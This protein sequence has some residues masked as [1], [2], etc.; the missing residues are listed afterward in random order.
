MK[1]TAKALSIIALACMAGCGGDET[2]VEMDI[3][4]PVTV[5]E[6]EPGSI[7]EYVTTTGTVTASKEVMVRS[8]MAG[9]YRKALNP[10]SNR[11]F[12]LG[13]TVKKDGIIVYLDNPEQENSIRIESVEMN[14]EITKN[15]YEKQQSLY[16]KGGVTLR[17]LRNAEKA[18]LD[19]RLNHE[20]ALL[21]LAKMKITAPFDGVITDIPY[22]TE[23]VKAASGSD[24]VQ[25][26]DYG[27]MTMDVSIPGK[28]MGDIAV[29][30]ETRLTNYT[31]PDKK[32]Q[33]RISQVSPAL[34]PETRTFD[35]VVTIDN[36]DL[37]FRPGMFVKA[38][39]VVR[40]SEDTIVVPKDIVLS[41]R[42]RRTVFVVDRGFARER[43]VRPGLENP[44][45]MEVLEGLASGDRLVVEGFETLRDGSKVRIV[46]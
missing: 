19:A 35:A 7:E 18:Y 12:V 29:G 26:M 6:I 4:V 43:T 41:R 34:D 9:F 10:R 21:Q 1:R 33:G 20:N 23:G 17:E 13:D 30:Q 22:Y 8:E 14:L 24:M 15:E 11:P 37:L 39:I 25:I 32:L 5:R 2:G 38:E 16:D 42:N 45:E 36:P 40:K 27:A 28:L 3:E 46:E 44:D 31:L